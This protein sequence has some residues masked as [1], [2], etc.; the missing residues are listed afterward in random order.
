[1]R[2]GGSKRL[3][4][5]KTLVYDAGLGHPQGKKGDRINAAPHPRPDKEVY[6]K[7]AVIPH[8]VGLNGRPPRV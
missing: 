7:T 4:P 3:W 8:E 1:M 6:V 2:R 5:P